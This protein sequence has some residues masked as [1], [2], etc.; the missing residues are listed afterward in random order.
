[1][2]RN[3]KAHAYSTLSERELDA[4]SSEF[5]R[6]FIADTFG[7]MPAAERTREQRARRKPGRPRI[8]QGATRISVTV[9]RGLLKELD[10]MARRLRLSRAQII[11]LGGRALLQRSGRSSRDPIRRA[12]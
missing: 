1:M 4:I 2:S 7:P 11:A 6:E 5:D 10:A 8:G 9:E 12:G 3:R